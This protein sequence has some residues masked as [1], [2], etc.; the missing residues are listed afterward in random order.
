MCAD[1][2]YR[3]PSS[4]FLKPLHISTCRRS[5]FTRLDEVE[6]ST[7]LEEPVGEIVLL[8]EQNILAK[9]KLTTAMR[10]R[11]QRKRVEMGG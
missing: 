1:L 9:F 5:A 7:I 10:Q 6:R 11:E 4:R 8:L 2:L 3:K